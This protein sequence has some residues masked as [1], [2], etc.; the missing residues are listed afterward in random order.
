MSQRLTRDYKYLKHYSPDVHQHI[1]K[2][3]PCFLPLMRVVYEQLGDSPISLGVPLGGVVAE[4]H[5][6]HQGYEDHADSWWPAAVLLLVSPVCI[7]EVTFAFGR[8]TQQKGREIGTGKVLIYFIFKIY[9]IR[10][11]FVLFFRVF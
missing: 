4:Q 5:D 6:L 1:G 10:Y 7:R 2:E 11:V 8:T 9:F 3:P